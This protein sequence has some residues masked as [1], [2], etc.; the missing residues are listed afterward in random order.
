MNT[1]NQETIFIALK[2][3]QEKK[4]HSQMYIYTKLSSYEIKKKRKK[5]S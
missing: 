5:K 4:L 2:T 1:E 3:Q